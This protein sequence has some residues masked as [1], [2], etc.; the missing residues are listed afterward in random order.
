M[1]STIDGWI[2]IKAERRRFRCQEETVQVLEA[3]DRER[4]EASA[5]VADA[6]G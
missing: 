6:A 5:A 2:K 3:K 1:A 4:E